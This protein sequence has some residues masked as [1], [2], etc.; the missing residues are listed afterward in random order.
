MPLAQLSRRDAFRAS[1][2][3]VTAAALGAACGDTKPSVEANGR[4]IP[5]E[6]IDGEA[7][8]LSLRR[9]TPHVGSTFHF[10]GADGESVELTLTS[11]TDLGLVGRPIVDKAECFSLSFAPTRALTA[12]GLAQDTYTVSHAALGKFPLFIVPGA[13]AGTPSYTA[14]FNRV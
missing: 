12:G 9:F 1:L 14:L 5:R 8:S 2:A 7:Y 6:A 13:K 4:V 3:G 10:A 11:A